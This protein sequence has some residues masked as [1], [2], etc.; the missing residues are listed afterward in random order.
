MVDLSHLAV[1]S[2]ALALCSALRSFCL[3]ALSYI[4][5]LCVQGVGSCPKSKDHFNM[6]LRVPWNV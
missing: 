5:C 3:L 4:L 6:K 1:L 2:A